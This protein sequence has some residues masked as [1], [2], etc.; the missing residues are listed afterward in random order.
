MLWTMS[1]P[2]PAPSAAPTRI[3]LAPGLFGF[4]R[5][6][7]FD[8]LQHVQKA[9]ADRF[10]R[11]GRSVAIR[12][13][14]V[15][16]SASIRRRAAR[17]VHLVAETCGSEGGPIHL[18]GH[19]TGGLDLRLVTSPSARLGQG[20]EG[21][22]G[23]LDRLASVTSMNTPHYGTPLAAHFATPNGQRLLYAVTAVT[24]A[25][26]RLGSPPLAATAALVAAPDRTRESAGLQNRLIDRITE[27][28]LQALDRQSRHDV[29]AWMARIQDD[30]GAILQLT[31]ESMDLFQANVDDRPGLRYQCAA[32]YAP[33]SAAR[34]W[35]SHLRS[36][37]PAVS[38]ALF[39][40]LYRS[41]A[42]RHPRYPCA[43]EDGADE[44]LRSMLGET[45]PADA[46]DGI[47]PLRSQLWGEPVWLGQADHLDVV[48]YFGHRKG[49]GGW[50]TCGAHFDGRSFGSMMDRIVEGMLEGEAGR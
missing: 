25:S 12:V 1:A 23:W 43:P 14:D 7:G 40:I 19:S 2:G 38:A 48:G 16:P 29:Q 3:Y 26:L 36:P 6:A 11:R 22:R 39:H 34:D 50:L 15:H 46:N 47:V 33:P 18:L 13:V 44:L 24:V 20:T 42:R 21:R 8:Y 17:L 45:P 27:A 31:P 10:D 35:V 30:Q 5:L 28:L 49:A 37:W 4:A 9:L 41:T 32:S